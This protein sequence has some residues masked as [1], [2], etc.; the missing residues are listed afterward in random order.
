MSHNQAARLIHDCHLHG[1]ADALSDHPQSAVPGAWEA[2]RLAA[3]IA[4]IQRR[5]SHPTN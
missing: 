2:D 1:I 4:E 5:K 3:V